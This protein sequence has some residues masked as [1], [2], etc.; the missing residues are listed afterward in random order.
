MLYTYCWSS[1]NA[2]LF[3]QYIMLIVSIL[4]KNE[5]YLLYFMFWQH[6]RDQFNEV[7]PALCN[8]FPDIFPQNSYTWEQY[9]WACEL[10][11][12]NGMKIKFSDGSIRTCLIP[13][14]GFLNHSVCIFSRPPSLSLMSHL[15]FPQFTPCS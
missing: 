1:N 12:S 8:T 6:L 15:L 5:V 10:W 4:Q 7:F 2:I 13:I 3:I 14:A 11:Y 9:L